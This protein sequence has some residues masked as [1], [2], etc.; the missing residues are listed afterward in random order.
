[1]HVKS[2]EPPDTFHLSAA[3]GWLGLGNWQDAH[4]ELAK[5]SPDLGG[6]PDVLVVRVEIYSKAGKWELAAEIAGVLIQIRPN[7]P[8]C[9]ISR[10]YATRR[11]PGG[12]IPQA[13]E[14]LSKAQPLFPKQPLIPYNLAC[15][16]CQLGD[17]DEARKWLKLALDLGDARQIKL[18]ALNDPDLE[19]LRAEIAEI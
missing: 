17:H 11:M 18:L 2:L 10:A 19:P 9:W 7:D 8:Q 13:R 6:H 12:G 14:I 5:I 16:A 15:Y 1:M 3:L 4:E